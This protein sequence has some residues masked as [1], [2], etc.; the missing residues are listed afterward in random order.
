MKKCFLST[1]HPSIHPTWS[2]G[3]YCWFIQAGPN[4]EHVQIP[5]MW[6]MLFIDTCLTQITTQITSNTYAYSHCIIA[7]WHFWIGHYNLHSHTLSSNHHMSQYIDTY[8][9]NSWYKMWCMR[10]PWANCDMGVQMLL[11][12]DTNIRWLVLEVYTTKIE[13]ILAVHFCYNS[14]QA[15]SSSSMNCK[16]WLQHLQ[17]DWK[18]SQKIENVTFHLYSQP[19]CMAREVQPHKGYL[20]LG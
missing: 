5:W 8:K 11:R 6:I 15:K 18:L 3:G 2:T 13:M 10:H 20:P 12:H 4:S 14:H 1:H 16:Q 19:A 17:L 9:L 7:I